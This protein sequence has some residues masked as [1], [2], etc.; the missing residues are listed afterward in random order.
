H[1][2]RNSMRFSIESRVPFLTVD[3]VDLLLSLPEN[4]LINLKG[5][6]KHVF[7]AAMRGIVPDDVLDRHD[8]IGFSTPER[9]WLLSMRSTVRKWLGEN[10][11]LEFLNQEKMLQEFD[12][13]AAGGK[14]FSWQVWRWVNF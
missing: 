5:E 10:I 2:D 13:I 14:P 8:K 12:L 11:H 6:T 3:M 7:R 4:H 9:D 1:G